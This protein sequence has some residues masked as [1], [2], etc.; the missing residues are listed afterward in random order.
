MPLNV[1]VATFPDGCNTA[2]AQPSLVQWDRG[3]ILQFAGFDLPVS[4][5]VEF[6]SP[7]T[8]LAIPALGDSAGVEIPNVLLQSSAPITAYLVLHEGE[9]D[10]ETEY[11][12]NKWPW[13]R[14]HRR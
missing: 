5:Q 4:Y 10:R 9:N 2:T 14:Q 12:R 1:T 7:E 11:W 13:G 6:S 8:V 3:Q